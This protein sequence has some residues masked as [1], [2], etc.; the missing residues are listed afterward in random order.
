MLLPLPI[1]D[2]DPIP[3]PAPVGLLKF[4]LILTFILHILAMNLALGGGLIA[5][6]YT[7]VG[8]AKAK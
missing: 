8:A 1:P 3:L 6:G 4:L 5:A 2:P 7:L